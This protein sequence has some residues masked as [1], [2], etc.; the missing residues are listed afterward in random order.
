VSIVRAR[1]L[2]ARLGLAAA[3]LVVLAG[4]G[5]GAAPPP[6]VC[7]Q[8]PV[9]ARVIDPF[10][11]PTCRWCPGNRGIEYGTKPGAVVR[12]SAVGRV[13]FAGLVAGARWVTIAHTADLVSTYGPLARLAVRRGQPVAAGQV[14]GVTR[15]VLHFGVRQSG[16]YVDPAGLLGPPA[17][18][19]PRLIPLWVVVHPVAARRCPAGRTAGEQPASTTVAPVR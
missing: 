11:A 4:S 17:H 5:A 8:P 6:V 14:V 12:A 2:A 10:R 7:L 18:L 3:S 13:S 1:P 16:D 19:V 15:G 9:T